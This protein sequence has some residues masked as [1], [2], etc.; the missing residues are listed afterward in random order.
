MTKIRTTLVA[1]C[2]IAM[3][4]PQVGA[5]AKAKKPPTLKLTISN[6]RYCQAE[7]CSPLDAGYLRTAD[8][9][10]AGFDNP[11]AIIDVKRG[12][13][14]VW[15]YRDGLCDSISGCPGH[16]VTLDSGGPAGKRVGFAAARA[17]AKTIKLKVAQKKG[18]LVRYFCSVNNHYQYGTSGILRVT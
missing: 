11:N 1:G 10:V 9:P 14:V 6:F 3:L 8:G 7:S 13:V 18:T 15:T 4:A 5:D 17:G 2:L 12:S 16:N